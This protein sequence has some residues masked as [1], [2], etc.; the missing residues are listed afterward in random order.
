MEKEIEMS[1]GHSHGHAVEY[2]QVDDEDVD[3]HADHDETFNI[4]T[5]D[6]T[7]VLSIFE[8]N[9]PPEFRIDFKD[10]KGKVPTATNISV[11]TTRDDGTQQPFKFM[12]LNAVRNGTYRSTL[13][14]PEPHQF[15]AAV[16]YLNSSG[17]KVEHCVNFVESD[18][19]SHG[20]HGH[21]HEDHGHSHGHDH[22]DS[23]DHEE[24]HD[25]GKTSKFHRDNNYRAAICHVV[26]DAFVSVLV[27]V[28]LCVIK[29]V[30]RK[31]NFLDPTMALVGACV[32]ISWSYTLI[33]DTGMNL[34]DKV[35][36]QHLN[37]ALIAKLE[38]DG[39]VVHDLHVWRLGPGHLGAII[40]LTAPNSSFDKTYYLQKIKKFKALSH[41]T[42]EIDNV[43]SKV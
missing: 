5:A 43:S 24:D 26:A 15:R 25:A 12:Q 9:I 18:D 8:E 19:H 11:S 17:V 7:L 1:H 33:R 10:W 34:L 20:H 41:I 21:A 6:G 39:S 2:Y 37:D 28:T 27:I 14:I 22:H 32:I 13:S 16:T 40:S 3:D 4:V 36:D 23:H 35:P 38:S 42:I 30:G 29:I 31:M